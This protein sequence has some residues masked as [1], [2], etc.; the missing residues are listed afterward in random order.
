MPDTLGMFPD[1]DL[2]YEGSVLHGVFPLLG[3]A[4]DIDRVQAAFFALF[5]HA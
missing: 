1:R 3:G 2:R 5:S 4:S